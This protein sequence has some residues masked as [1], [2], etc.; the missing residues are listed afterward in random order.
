MPGKDT[1]K[2]FYLATLPFKAAKCTQPPGNDGINNVQGLEKWKPFQQVL[3]I[4][5]LCYR[6]NKEQ[7]D[8]DLCKQYRDKTQPQLNVPK[9]RDE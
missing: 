4:V 5:K 6:V 8:N 1:T 7:L 2:L 9:P 3:L